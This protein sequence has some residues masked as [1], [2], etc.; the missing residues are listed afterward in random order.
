[1]KTK[2]IKVNTKQL[3]GRR[4]MYIVPGDSRDEGDIYDIE[5]SIPA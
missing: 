3:G 4:T 2:I 1:V 5:P